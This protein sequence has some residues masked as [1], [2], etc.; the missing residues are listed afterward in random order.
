ML[1]KAGLL[2]WHFTVM[3]LGR[4]ALLAC[5]CVH[6]CTLPESNPPSLLIWDCAKTR[7]KYISRNSLFYFLFPYQFIT[8][9]FWMTSR[10]H[11]K[12]SVEKHF[13]CW[14]LSLYKNIFEDVDLS[15]WKSTEEQTSFDPEECILIYSRMWPLVCKLNQ[16]I[17]YCT[18]QGISIFKV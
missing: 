6:S 2:F 10:Q 18:Y 4:S 11:L 5:T 16:L 15:E 17:N 7:P 13:R 1:D 8:S 14:T 9:S 12:L 3:L